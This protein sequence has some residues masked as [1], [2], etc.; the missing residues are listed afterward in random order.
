[1]KPVKKNRP[2]G[3]PLVILPKHS[4][5]SLLPAGSVLFWNKSAKI[6]RYEVIFGA[7]KKYK[8]GGPVFLCG[9]VFGGWFQGIEKMSPIRKADTGKRPGRGNDDAIGRGPVLHHSHLTKSQAPTVNLRG[10][11]FGFLKG[12]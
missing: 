6:G 3:E 8:A 7:V 4:T 5:S 12:F 1:M 2:G 9:C 11:P 10:L